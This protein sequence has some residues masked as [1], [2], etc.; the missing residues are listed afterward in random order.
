MDDDFD[1]ILDRL[2][3]TPVDPRLAT[4]RSLVMSRIAAGE[5]QATRALSL[6][7]GVLAV[8]ALA[9]GI[10][11]AGVP[12]AS[13]HAVPVLAPFA[14]DTPLAPSSLLIGTR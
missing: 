4:N 7:F 12:G 2:A 5:G 14:S 1:L 11:S 10:A 13:A 3:Q 9:M 8:V 6:Q